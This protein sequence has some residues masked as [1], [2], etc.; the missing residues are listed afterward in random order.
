MLYGVY[1]KNE[2]LWVHG[3]LVELGFE[4]FDILFILFKLDI[5]EKGAA[6]PEFKAIAIFH[7]VPGLLL[8]IPVS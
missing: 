8:L 4:L 7:H 1:T 5:W 3:A 2:N 6:K